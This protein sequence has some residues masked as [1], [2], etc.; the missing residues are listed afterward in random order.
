MKDERALKVFVVVLKKAA[1]GVLPWQPSKFENIFE[2]KMP[3]GFLVR[4]YPYTSLDDDGDRIG[5][6]SL[7]LYDAAEE[8]I[9]DITSDIDGVTVE[10]LE[11]IYR[12][13]RRV[14]LQVDAKLDAIARD[15]EE[16]K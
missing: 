10:G 8:L 16:L 14:A 11:I 6:A 12:E 4:A 5:A 1:A 7:T 2:F 15:L 13:A 9:F 3:S